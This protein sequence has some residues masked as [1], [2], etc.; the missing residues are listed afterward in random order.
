MEPLPAPISSLRACDA[1]SWHVDGGLSIYN[2][3]CDAGLYIQ[4][5]DGSDPALVLNGI[6]GNFLDAYG[7]ATFETDAVIQGTAS[8]QGTT[9]FARSGVATVLKGKAN[10]SLAFSGNLGGSSVLA[11]IQQ[12]APGVWVISA[13][14]DAVHNAIIIHLNKQATTPIKVAWFVLN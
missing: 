7:T 8:F 5:H 3:C 13:V 2:E 12:N 1:T 11:T 9:T 10:V 14:P 4:T 6:D